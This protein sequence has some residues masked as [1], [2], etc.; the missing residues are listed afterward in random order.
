MGT[1]P[2]GVGTYN[3]RTEQATD[4]AVRTWWAR[5]LADQN[6]NIATQ[7]LVIRAA[8]ALAD[9]FPDEM[10]GEFHRLVAEKQEEKK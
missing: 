4:K 7:D 9:R 5:L 8:M 3:L 1:R 2:R 10:I 6:K